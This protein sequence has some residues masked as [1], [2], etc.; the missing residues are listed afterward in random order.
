MILGHC[1]L[2]TF[3]FL[4]AWRNGNILQHRKLTQGS[5][6]NSHRKRQKDKGTNLTG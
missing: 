2:N 5:S 6:T 4:D 1:R 3:F